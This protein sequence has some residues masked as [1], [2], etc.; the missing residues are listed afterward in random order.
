MGTNPIISLAE[1]GKKVA[2]LK[3]N[4]DIKSKNVENLK[5]SFLKY[6]NLQPAM[7]CDATKAD[8]DNL[9]VVDFETSK[10][11]TGEALN[12]YVVILDGQH[13]YKAY[14]ELKSERN[15]NGEFYV[16]YPLNDK[17][18]IFSMIA[19]MNKVVAAWKG[20]DY[21]KCAVNVMTDPCV[22]IKELHNLSEMGIKTLNAASTWLTLSGNITTGAIKKYIESEGE[23]CTAALTNTSN[24]DTGKKLLKAA[25]DAG[26][27]SKFL[28]RANF[29]NWIVCKVSQKGT[30]ND[31]AVDKMIEFIK[32]H[33]YSVINANIER[34]DADKA[35]NRKQPELKRNNWNNLWNNM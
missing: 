26:Y 8:E 4:R 21:V 20:E 5:N 23:I 35:A 12:E 2:L 18:T 27:K 7:I 24:I 6:G 22:M 33:S 30:I 14:S 34:T 31:A 11:I 15:Y 9:E 13:R 16:Y 32:K 19:E 25:L 3:G 1:L 17:A 28:D 29:V 10:P